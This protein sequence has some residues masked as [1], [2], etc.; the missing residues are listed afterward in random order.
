M[1]AQYPQK[2]KVAILPVVNIMHIKT[3]EDGTIELSGAEG[4][5]LNVVLSS[6]GLR[7]DFV[8]PRDGQHGK[9][10]PG[11]NW[12]GMIGMVQRGE[13]DLAYSYLG[14][15]ESRSRVVEFSTPYVFEE[16]TFVSQIPKN[17]ISLF[18]FLYPFD[19][20][21]WLSLLLTFSLISFLLA[22]CKNHVSSV[23]NYAYRLFGNILRQSIR[24]GEHSLKFNL[25]VVLWMLSVQVIVFSYS[26][27]LLSFLIE[28]LKE[29]PI[30]NFFELSKAVLGGS[31]Q[32]NFS[33]FAVP[34]LLKSDKEYLIKL[35]KIV[36]ENN[37]IV[38]Y[39][40]LNTDTYIKPNFFLGMNRNFGKLLFGTRDD[41]YFSEDRLY[42]VFAGFAYN[43]RFCCISKLNAII[44]RASSAGLYQ[45]FLKDDSIKSFLKSFKRSDSSETISPLSAVAILGPITLLGTGLS[46][47]FVIF[48][49][50]VIYSKYV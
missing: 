6:L 21:T 38:N 48:L 31:Y 40:Q 9:L 5:F 27:T 22:L 42:H 24:I 39:S 32:A 43:K 13:A 41:V 28:P 29:D 11:G 1:K 14:I 45:K 23:G 46:I 20:S 7:Y 16:F 35:G 3:S 15:T 44:Y 2:I 33:D 37:W 26:G 18:T 10:L 49:A 34:F 17:R 4:R 12:S 50:E 25:L 30:R 8:I 19:L 47:A 36:T